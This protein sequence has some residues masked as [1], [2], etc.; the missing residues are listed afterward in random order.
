MTGA[1]EDDVRGWVVAVASLHDHAVQDQD[2][3]AAADAA[4]QLW[5]GLGFRAAPTPVLEMLVQ[6]IDAGYA[7]ALRDLREGS[8]DD[9]NRA[10]RTDLTPD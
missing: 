1:S 5:S 4:A 3:C 10:W 9:A 2:A 7:A 8:L 6:A